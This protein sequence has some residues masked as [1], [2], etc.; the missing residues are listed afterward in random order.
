MLNKCPR[1][2]PCG[3]NPSKLLVLKILVYVRCKWFCAVKVSNVYQAQKRSRNCFRSQGCNRCPHPRGAQREKDT[4]QHANTMLPTV[5]HGISE[6]RG[7][8][9]GVRPRPPETVTL[10]CNLK[11]EQQLTGLKGQASVQKPE[12]NYSS[13]C[14]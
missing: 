12:E 10:G 11:A 4:I 3:E 7:V 6:L 1:T 9:W 14:P 2:D 13:K 5:I 8:T